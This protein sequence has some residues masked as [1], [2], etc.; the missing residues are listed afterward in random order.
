M[1]NERFKLFKDCLI[2]SFN[3]MSE[4]KMKGLIYLDIDYFHRL[5]KNKKAKK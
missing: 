1:I 4:I 2:P 5:M 3:G